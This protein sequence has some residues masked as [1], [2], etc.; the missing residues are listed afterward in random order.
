[1]HATNA[2][3]CVCDSSLAARSHKPL[4]LLRYDS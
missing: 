3:P 1:M 2:R 4:H